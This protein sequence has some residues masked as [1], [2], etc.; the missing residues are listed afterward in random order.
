MEKNKETLDIF[1]SNL[2]RIHVTPV[3]PPPSRLE[4]LSAR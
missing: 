4:A 3:T 1:A 2:A